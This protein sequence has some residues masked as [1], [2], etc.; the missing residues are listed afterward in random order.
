MRR[1]G[2][3]PAGRF[4]RDRS[5][6]VYGGSAGAAL[7]PTPRQVLPNACRARVS[8]EASRRD[9]WGGLEERYGAE[10][11]GFRGLNVNSLTTSPHQMKSLFNSNWEGL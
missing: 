4:L 2:S 7:D 6:V 8:I 1:R 10:I 3:S 11:R 9:S 5:G